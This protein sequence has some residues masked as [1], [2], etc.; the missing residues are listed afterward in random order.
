MEIKIR[1]CAHDEIPPAI[2]RVKTILEEHIR[3]SRATQIPLIYTLPVAFLS[4]IP[5][6]N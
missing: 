3:I 1:V 4:A 6:P 2:R 5:S